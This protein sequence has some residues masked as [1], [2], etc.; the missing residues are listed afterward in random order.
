MAVISS[1]N[2][3]FFPYPSKLQPYIS[4]YSSAGIVFYLLT[5]T[6]RPVVGNI[7]SLGVTS[8]S[9]VTL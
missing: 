9:A 8:S 1:I 4:F 2:K 3:S 5:D 6:H 7:F